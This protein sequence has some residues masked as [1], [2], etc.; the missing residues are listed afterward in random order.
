M[1]KRVSNRK[2]KKHGARSSKG[3]RRKRGKSRLSAAQMEWQT[4]QLAAKTLSAKMMRE[5]QEDARKLERSFKNR[6]KKA[7]S[8]IFSKAST[9]PWRK[10]C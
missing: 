9:F 3:A 1:S 10:G 2:G 7:W 5:V 8:R 6:I 4:E